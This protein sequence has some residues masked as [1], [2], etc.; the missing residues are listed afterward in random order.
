MPDRKW[1]YETHNDLKIE[2]LLAETLPVC[3]RE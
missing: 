3:S 2:F 1:K